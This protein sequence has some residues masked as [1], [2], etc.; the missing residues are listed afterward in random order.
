MYFV[1]G[2]EI[3]FFLLEIHSKFFAAYVILL[4]HLSPISVLSYA[5]AAVL[6]LQSGMA[7]A[8]CDLCLCGPYRSIKTNKQATTTK[9]KTQT[10]FQIFVKTFQCI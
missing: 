8:S 3:F 6:T 2:I 7:L 1:I 5:A 4:E 10:F 9:K